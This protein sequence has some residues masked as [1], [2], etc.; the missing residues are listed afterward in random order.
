[1]V[2]MKAG[3]RKTAAARQN[4]VIMGFER[5]TIKVGSALLV[6]GQSG[7]LRQEWLNS[8]AADI[9]RLKKTGMQVLVVS[10]GAISLGRSILGLEEKNLTLAQN[11]A[12]ASVGQ[13]ALAQAWSDA[14]GTRRMTAGQILLTPNITEERRHYI[15]A[16][17]TI[18]TLL[19][20]GAVPVINENDTVATMEIR[21]GD[22]DRLSAR[23]ASMVGSDCLVLLSDIDGLYTSAP[24]R[25]G[26]MDENMEKSIVH[27]PR[28]DAVTPEIEAMASGARNHL[29]RG[30]MATKL[31]AAKIAMRAGTSM[32]IASG[33]GKHPI[34][35]LASGARHTL[36]PASHSPAAARKSWI[37]GT[38]E[39]AGR[40]HVDGGAG[41]AL[42]RGKSLLPV[43]VK[44][45]CGEFE[46]GDAVSIFDVDGNEIARG[47][48][49]MNSKE[50]RLSM[51]K[52]GEVIM[53]MFGHMNRTELV[54]SDNLVMIASDGERE[55]GPGKISDSGNGMN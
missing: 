34:A 3:S 19:Q 18:L 53:G 31:D 40:I 6:D 29:A 17:A 30:G 45:I 28:V 52:K 25:D 9:S 1:M 11:Q 37:L 15:N 55:A 20:M 22:N 14:L 4:R 51:G 26:G 47:L 39:V 2:S 33:T 32:I 5:I 46:R 23:V 21:Y 7:Q 13:I 41:K 36:F 35:A 10:S 38:L 44:K 54:H 8:L 27:L 43:G 24:D 50:A 49:A 16:R 12:C 42:K 48:V